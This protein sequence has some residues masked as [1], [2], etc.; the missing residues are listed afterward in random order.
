MRIWLIYS[1]LAQKIIM[2]YLNITELKKEIGYDKLKM[3][4][5]T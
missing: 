4:R 1:F 5:E 2:S 3:E